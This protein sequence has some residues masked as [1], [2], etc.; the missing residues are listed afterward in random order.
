MN[1]L[2]Q[3]HVEDL[4]NLLNNYLVEVSSQ[5]NRFERDSLKNL[6]ELNY[7]YIMSGLKEFSRMIENNDPMIQHLI[8]GRFNDGFALHNKALLLFFIDVAIMFIGTGYEYA[9]EEK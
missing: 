7:N 2:T 5:I 1:P 9:K 6:N 8:E 3:I 4:M